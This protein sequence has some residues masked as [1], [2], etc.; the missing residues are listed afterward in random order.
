[1]YGTGLYRI[2]AVLLSTYLPFLFQRQDRQCTYKPN[3]EARSRNHCCSGKAVSTTQSQCVCVCVC[4]SVTLVMKHAKR[5]RRMYYT[6]ICGLTG[7]TTFST[8][9]HKR[10][11][12]GKKKLLNN[13]MCF[14]FDYKFCRKHFSF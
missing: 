13:K 5:M 10:H 8:L 11:F 1:M 7:S 2:A 3:N 9:S 12:Q 6:V 14:D 4:L